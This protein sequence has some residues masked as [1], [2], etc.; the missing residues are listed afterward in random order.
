[1]RTNSFRVRR[2]RCNAPLRKVI[3]LRF[4]RACNT[5][6]THPRSPSCTFSDSKAT[7]LPSY[8][9]SAWKYRRI[10]RMRMARFEEVTEPRAAASGLRAQL[11]TFSSI[12]NPQL[13][14]LSRSLL[15]AVLYLLPLNPDQV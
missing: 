11:S 12:H 4:I 10:R 6:L 14:H 7:R 3:W 9:T 8:G 1:M 13:E 15:L 5:H 2:S